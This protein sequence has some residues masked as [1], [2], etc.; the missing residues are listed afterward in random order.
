MVGT[1]RFVF[2]SDTFRIVIRLCLPVLMA[3]CL[4]QVVFAQQRVLTWSQTQDQIPG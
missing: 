4:A 2:Q 1:S 3:T